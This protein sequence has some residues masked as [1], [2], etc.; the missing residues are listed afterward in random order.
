MSLSG[1]K[2]YFNPT[3][4]FS[5]IRQLA[6]VREETTMDAYEPKEHTPEGRDILSSWGL[7]VAGS[8]VLILLAQVGGF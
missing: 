6:A 5:G 2:E 8:F 7:A 4:Q 3:E 1:G